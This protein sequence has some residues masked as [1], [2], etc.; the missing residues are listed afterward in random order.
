[1]FPKFTL[2]HVGLFTLTIISGEVVRDKR[3]RRKNEDADKMLWK[4]EYEEELNDA[5]LS[6]KRENYTRSAGAQ[7]NS[8]NDIVIEKL[9]ESITSSERYLKKIEAIEFRLNRLDIEV[10]EKTNAIMK[11]LNNISKSVR[12][13]SSQKFESIIHGLVSDVTSIKY[14]V[15]KNP[16]AS[17]SG[18]GTVVVLLP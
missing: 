5:I 13:D 15:E 10:H 1:M 6:G 9:M 4:K 18:T 3:G 12:A 16:R 2:L 8:D 11:L 7:S 17:L 14:A